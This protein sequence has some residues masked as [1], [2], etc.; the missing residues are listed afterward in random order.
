MIR[1]A[2]ARNGASAA[3]LWR[4]WIAPTT[5]SGPHP[6]RWPPESCD[7]EPGMNVFDID[8]DATRAAAEHEDAAAAAR[9][10]RLRPQFRSRWSPRAPAEIAFAGGF[11]SLAQAN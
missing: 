3:K 1:S 11:G 6:V 4:R 8:A 9:R 5:E 7:L 2:R 10:D